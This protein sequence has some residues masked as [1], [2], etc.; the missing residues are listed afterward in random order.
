[1]KKAKQKKNLENGEGGQDLGKNLLGRQ[2]TQTI[3]KKQ[4]LFNKS[5]TEIKRTSYQKD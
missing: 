3:T 5:Q 1:M 2:A 4:K